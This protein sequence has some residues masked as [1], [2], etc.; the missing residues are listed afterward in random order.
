MRM[1]SII[2]RVVERPPKIYNSQITSP[3]RFIRDFLG[4]PDLI[5]SFKMAP[6]DDCKHYYEDLVSKDQVRKSFYGLKSA[7]AKAIYLFT[8]TTS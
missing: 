1:L 7:R 2:L 6:V 8:A 4:L 3:R 5:M